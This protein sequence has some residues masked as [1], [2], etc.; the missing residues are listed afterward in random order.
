MKTSQKVHLW[1]TITWMLVSMAI[2]SLVG[3]GVTGSI[4]VGLSVGI[5][6]RV[7]KTIIYFV[8]ERVWHKR[9]KQLKKLKKDG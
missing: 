7:I 2:T 3:W 4:M 1:K 5:I 6:D 8:H 9:Y